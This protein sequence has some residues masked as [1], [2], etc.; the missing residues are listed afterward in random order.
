MEVKIIGIDVDENSFQP[1]FKLEILIPFEPLQD[2]KTKGADKIY[3]VIGRALVDG[4]IKAHKGLEFTYDQ[5]DS[6]Q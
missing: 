2:A 4:I 1:R 3:E 6:L 5:K